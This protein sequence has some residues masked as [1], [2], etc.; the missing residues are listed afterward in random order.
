MEAVGNFET[1]PGCFAGFMDSCESRKK[2]GIRCGEFHF[3]KLLLSP[4]HLE[5]V[6]IGSFRN[7][8]YVAEAMTAY[9]PGIKNLAVN[10]HGNA[11]GGR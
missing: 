10:S 4:Q 2:L 6:E 7:L 3:R 5:E 11:K 1:H 8:G 9:G